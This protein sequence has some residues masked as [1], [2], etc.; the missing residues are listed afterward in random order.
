MI[1]PCNLDGLGKS[2]CMNGCGCEEVKHV[3]LSGCDNCN[4]RCFNQNDNLFFGK[5]CEYVPPSLSCGS[6]SISLFVNG[7]VSNQ[8]HSGPGLG[9]VTVYNGCDDGFYNPNCTLFENI[10]ISENGQGQV[11]SYST[12]KPFKYLS[13]LLL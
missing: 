2:P 7:D 12:G 5:H 6:R 8:W 3:S 11:Q 9:G 1:Q 10:P 4:Y 13:R